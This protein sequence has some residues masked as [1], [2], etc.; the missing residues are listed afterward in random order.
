MPLDLGFLDRVVNVHW[1]S[2]LAVIFG[3]QDADAV[4]P[5]ATAKKEESKHELSGNGPIP[6]PRHG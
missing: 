4:E 6:T 5:E 3:A 2:G 1:I